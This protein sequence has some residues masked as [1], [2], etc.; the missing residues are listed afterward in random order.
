[1]CGTLRLVFSGNWVNNQQDIVTAGNQAAD[2]QK[3]ALAGVLGRCRVLGTHL[4]L[5]HRAAGKQLGS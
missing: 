5:S 2:K 3:A 4:E 1:M